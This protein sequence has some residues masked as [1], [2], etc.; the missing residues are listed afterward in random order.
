MI[1]IENLTENKYPLCENNGVYAINYGAV[2]KGAD[3]TV[4]LLLKDKLNILHVSVKASCGCTTPIATQKDE[5][6]I[7]LVISYNSQLLGTINK[8]VTETFKV[9]GQSQTNQVVIHLNGTV[10]L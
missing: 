10:T 6:T 5:N 1:K 2:K 9:A 3:M 7:E 8:K 4:T